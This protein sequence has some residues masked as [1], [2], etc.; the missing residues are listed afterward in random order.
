MSRNKHLTKLC[1]K[2]RFHLKYV[3]AL[4]CEIEVSDRAVSVI[5]TFTC[6]F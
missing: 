3:L 5:I 1:M 6:I 2:C 4:P